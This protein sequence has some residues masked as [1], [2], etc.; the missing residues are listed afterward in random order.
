MDD[1]I[2]LPNMK[3]SIR[4][5]ALYKMT[6]EKSSAREKLSAPRT[7]GSRSL[8]LLAEVDPRR[9]LLG[10]SSSAEEF[11]TSPRM[12]AHTHGEKETPL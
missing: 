12:R 8:R 3:I 9:A 6:K 4:L 11:K 10:M 1:Y 2:R 5:N 7:K